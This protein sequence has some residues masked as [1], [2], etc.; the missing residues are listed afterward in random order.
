MAHKISVDKK[1]QFVHLVYTGDVDIQERIA[2]R[3]EVFNLCRQN[4]FNR[5]LVET[6][7]SD[8]HITS[9]E[10][11][12]FARTFPQENLPHNYHVA[13]V[14]KINDSE[15]SILEIVASSHGLNI[16]AFT[17]TAEALEWLLAF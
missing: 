1:Q 4:N 3:N 6:Q 5:S 14:I 15:N 8:L 2:A 16:R 17:E 9:G 13:T 12:A 10:L 7:N 11:L